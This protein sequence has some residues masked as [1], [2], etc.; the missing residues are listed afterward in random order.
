MKSRNA[1]VEKNLKIIVII[2]IVIILV[3][4][5]LIIDLMLEG[6]DKGSLQTNGETA[7]E[8]I[9][10]KEDYVITQGV[11]LYADADAVLGNDV[12]M[13]AKLDS[14]DAESGEVTGLNVLDRKNQLHELYIEDMNLMSITYNG[15][16]EVSLAFKTGGTARAIVGSYLYLYKTEQGEWS[17]DERV[18]YGGS[19]QETSGTVAGFEFAAMSNQTGHLYLSYVLLSESSGQIIKL[20][21]STMNIQSIL[22]NGEM[23]IY[24]AGESEGVPIYNV[25]T[26]EN[27]WINVTLNDG[28]SIVFAPGSQVN[29]Q[30][31]SKKGYWEMEKT[32]DSNRYRAIITDF[33]FGHDD[34]RVTGIDY[35]VMSVDGGSQEKMPLMNTQALYGMPYGNY[36]RTY[37][38][39]DD[40]LVVSSVSP[41]E[42]WRAELY[43]NNNV[44]L[45]VRVGT[46]VWIYKNSDDVYVLDYEY[47]YTVQQSQ[48]EN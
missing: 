34:S 22:S 19:V 46:E 47:T 25:K 23:T 43:Y 17:P 1:K 44:V 35:I 37:T 32:I 14:I 30:Q 41:A 15:V 8:A 24:F 38:N 33:V 39:D 18:L 26:S 27:F 6:R 3:F 10:S 36:K 2:G 16:D 48:K 40:N 12:R 5:F 7:P 21:L 13:L 42:D 29:V 4:A 11:N 9:Y 20:P 31:S 45:S 28:T